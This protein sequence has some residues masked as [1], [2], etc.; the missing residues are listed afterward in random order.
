MTRR[1]TTPTD[2]PP[3]TLT[4][5]EAARIVRIGRSTAYKL[6]K[7][8]EETGGTSGLPMKWVGCQRRVPRPLLEEF[9]GGPITWPIPDVPA[10]EA[11]ADGAPADAP[12]EPGPSEVPAPI[13]LA[14]RRR[15]KR[16][17]ADQLALDVE[18]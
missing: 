18:P 7:E 11:P 2:V 12:A 6:V 13:P 10:V 15:A 8:Y 1:Q 4:V 9:L 17:A 14:T 5:E 3:D 16:V